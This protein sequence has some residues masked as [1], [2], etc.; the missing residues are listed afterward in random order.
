MGKRIPMVIE[1]YSGLAGAIEAKTIVPLA[2]ASP[3]RL[4]SFP[5][6]P[7]AAETLP[8]FE[9][10]GWQVLVAPV[11]TPDAI[12]Q[13]INAD[14]IKAMSDPQTRERLARFHR[15]HRPISPAETTAFIQGEQNKWAP[16]LQQI[17][18]AQK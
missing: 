8:G 10:G 14:L 17:A 13:K 12:V 5:D 6:V 2:V 4:P 9:S 15:D 3:Q 7:T 16:I 18:A 11:G 1:A